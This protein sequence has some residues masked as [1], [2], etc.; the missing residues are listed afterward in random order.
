MK[1]IVGKKIGMSQIFDSEGKVIPVTVIKATPMFI[2]QIKTK[3][4]DGYQAVQ[5]GFGEKK[6]VNKAQ[7]GHIKKA[8]LE[9][10]FA[11]FSEIRSLEELADN[12]KGK[13]IDVSI[14]IE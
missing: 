6:E 7:K 13:K 5:F 4:K 3:E 10:L 9:N 12:E 2:T 14:F 11:H 1:F 8:G